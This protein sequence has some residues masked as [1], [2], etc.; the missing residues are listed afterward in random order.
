MSSAFV[1]AKLPQSEICRVS[2]SIGSE[3]PLQRVQNSESRIPSAPSCLHTLAP[4]RSRLA[5]TEVS[6]SV[7]SELPP[8]P[9]HL[10]LLGDT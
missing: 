5:L 4:R 8:H 1:G 3:I 2:D 6:N 9:R 10:A 7:G